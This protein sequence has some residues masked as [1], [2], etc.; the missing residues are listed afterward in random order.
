MS[1][2]VLKWILLILF[3]NRVL[4]LPVRNVFV[5][6]RATDGIARGNIGDGG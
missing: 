6:M 3:L 5:G 2:P 4:V 1:G